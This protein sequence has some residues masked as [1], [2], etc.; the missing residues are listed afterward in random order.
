MHSLRSFIDKA[1]DNPAERSG[2]PEPSPHHWKFQNVLLNPTFYVDVVGNLPS[3]YL[4]KNG[5]KI[6]YSLLLWVVVF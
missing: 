6:L 2:G 3:D 1:W 4:K 5:R